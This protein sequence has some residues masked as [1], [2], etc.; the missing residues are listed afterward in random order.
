VLCIDEQ[1]QVTSAR[2]LGDRPAWLR[3]RLEHDLRTFRFTPVVEAGVAIPV[4]FARPIVIA[5][6]H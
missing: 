5:S 2:L 6:E 3:E 4:C 1:G